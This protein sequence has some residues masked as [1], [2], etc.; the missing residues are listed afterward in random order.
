M[1]E[2][3]VQIEVVTEKADDGLQG[4]EAAGCGMSTDSSAS[5]NGLEQHPKTGCI[6]VHHLS[7]SSCSQHSHAPRCADIS[8][9]KSRAIHKSLL[10]TLE[11]STLYDPMLLF[12]FVRLLACDSSA[13]APLFARSLLRLRLGISS[14]ISAAVHSLVG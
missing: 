11:K 2:A 6:S 5:V 4:H 1:R 13:A 9:V 7:L 10:E 3:R 14:V 8:P 12:S